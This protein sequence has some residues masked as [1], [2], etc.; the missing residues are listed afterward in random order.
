LQREHRNNI[1]FLRLVLA[2]AVIVGHAPELIDGNRHREALALIAPATSLGNMAVSGFFLLSGYLITQS[3]MSTAA[4]ASYLER[5][6]LRIVPGYVVAYLSSFFVVAPMLGAEVH[7]RAAEAVINML[8]LKAPPEL[9]ELSLHYAS[10]NAALWTIS[11][12]FRCYLLVAL[13]WAAGLLVRR[14]M[15][16]AL[17]GMALL[18]V[19]STANCWRVS[20]TIGQLNQI[21]AFDLLFGAPSSAILLTATFLVGACTYLYRAEMALFVS[22]RMAAACTLLLLLALCSSHTADVARASLFAIPLFWLAFRA[23]LGPLRSINDRWDISYGTYLY[24]WPVSTTILLLSGTISPLSL[25]L[26]SL[27]I[28]WLLGVAS[29]ICVERWPRSLRLMTI[30]RRDHG[31]ELPS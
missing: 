7:K 15:M 6:I 19:G 4:I 17:T 12:E 1:G 10:M 18:A 25:T 20:S 22:G 26:L 2:S 16:L 28:A 13:L 11:Y 9:R 27:P 23:N 14:R 8:F 21:R 31:Q 3:M 29:W 30:A 5:R 24:G